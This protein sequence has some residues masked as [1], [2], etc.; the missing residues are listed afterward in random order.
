MNNDDDTDSSV[1]VFSLA[2]SFFQNPH[3]FFHLI[4]Y[5]I[6]IALSFPIESL[7]IPFL[8]GSLINELYLLHGHDRQKHLHQTI[9]LFVFISLAWVVNAIAYSVMDYN[10]SILIPEFNSFVRNFILEKTIVKHENQTDDIHMGSLTTKIV[11]LPDSITSFFNVFIT[12]V[13]PRL[14]VVFAILLYFF[15][16]NLSVG[17]ILLFGILLLWLV[18]QNTIHECIDLYVDNNQVY[19]DINEEQKDTLLNLWNVF[20]SGKKQDELNHHRARND[21][22]RDGYLSSIQCVNRIKAYSYIIHICLFILILSTVLY[23]FLHGKI[24]LS[25]VVTVFIVM[26]Y[27]LQ[28]LMDITSLAPRMIEDY[29]SIRNSH[30]FIGELN[31]VSLDSRPAIRVFHGTIEFRDVSYVLE[32]DRLLFRNLNLYVSANQKICIV[33]KSGSGKSTLVKLLMGYYPVSAGT[34]LIDSQDCSLFSGESIREHIS[35]VGQNVSLF[36]KSIYENIVYSSPV[37]VSRETV[38]QLIASLGLQGV[39]SSIHANIDEALDTVVGVQ[40]N[41]LS[42]GQKQ[43]VAVLRELLCDKKILVLDEPT[44]AL[45]HQNKHTIMGIVKRITGKTVIVITHDNEF[46]GSVDVSYLLKD[47]QL[48]PV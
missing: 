39:F 21:G 33:G 7:L 46:L 20:S 48:M 11:S 42:G 43:I 10:D 9:V 25:V 30:E 22:L 23:L 8:T 26:I 36:N 12:Y 18:V 2:F 34:I 17:F 27:L 24:K 19:E 6:S 37:S 1:G 44:S 32:N 4:V 41:K 14:F 15:S 5:F 29:G 28:Y 3:A 16:L 47:G 40:G 38:I 45:D 31:A 13:F 35:Y